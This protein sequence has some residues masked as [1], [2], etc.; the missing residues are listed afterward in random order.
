MCFLGYV[1]WKTRAQWMERARLGDAP[2]PLVQEFAKIKCG[3]VV[4]PTC[5]RDGRPAATVRLR[6]VM[7][8]D[9]AQQELLQRLGLTLPKRL[10]RSEDN[11]AL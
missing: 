7:T 5:R 8:T 9:K 1:L 2:R 6:C 11:P 4:V 10:R 3:E